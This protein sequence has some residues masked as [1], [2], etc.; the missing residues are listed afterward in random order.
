MKN[1]AVISIDRLV[2]ESLGIYTGLDATRP[3]DDSAA[4][5]LALA[6]KLR[7]CGTE[8]GALGRVAE[9][10]VEWRWRP[11]GRMGISRVRVQKKWLIAVLIEPG[12]EQF[13]GGAGVG[14]AVG[15]FSA[16]PQHGRILQHVV[17]SA[18]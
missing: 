9:L 8:V 17:E 16:V 3:I 1:L 7:I 13:I 11:V 6:A 4:P 12:E 2:D 14:G 15:C 10:R 5:V 18:L